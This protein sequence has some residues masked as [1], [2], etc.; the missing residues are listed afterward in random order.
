MDDWKHLS[1]IDDSIDFKIRGIKEF[2]L[3]NGFLIKV[4]FLKAFIMSLIESIDF[5]LHIFSEVIDFQLG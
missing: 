4:S 3:F 2:S 1:R 5:V